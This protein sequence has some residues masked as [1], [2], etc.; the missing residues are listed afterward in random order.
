M[1]V[2]LFLA[3]IFCAMLFSLLFIASSVDL[4]YGGKALHV[5]ML[6]NP[7]HLESANPV[8]V[9]KARGRQMSKK[10]GHYGKH[11]DSG[12]VVCLQIHGDAAVAAQ[13]GE[14]G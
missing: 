9:G 2:N 10:V 3:V 7:S 1:Q 12:K 11:D 13:V 14:G 8:A 5:T 6:P 4:T